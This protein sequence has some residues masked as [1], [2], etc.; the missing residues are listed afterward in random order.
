MYA[1]V[2]AKEFSL[3]W[4]GWLMEVIIGT[5]LFAHS[6]ELVFGNM[7][8]AHSQLA[9]ALSLLLEVVIDWLFD[10]T[11][12]SP[13]SLSLALGNTFY[14]ARATNPY[15]GRLGQTCIIQKC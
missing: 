7:V 9:S 10:L 4:S 1:H 8:V 12:L 11:F 3:L 5:C 6:Q 2:L 13:Q 14:A 15:L